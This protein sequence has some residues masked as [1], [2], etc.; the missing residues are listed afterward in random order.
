MKTWPEEF[1]SLG[2]VA[3]IPSNLFDFLLISYF[4]EIVV[5][6][7]S[8]NNFLGVYILVEAAWVK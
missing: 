2:E 5:K 1:T 8:F 4:G 3:T 7:L 6:Y